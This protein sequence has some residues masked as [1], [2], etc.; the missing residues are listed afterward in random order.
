M[1][2][3]SLGYHNLEHL[4]QQG[5]ITI[6]PQFQLDTISLLAGKYGPF[7]P[8]HETEIPIWFALILYRAKVCKLKIPA[9]LAQEK[10]QEILRYEKENSSYYPLP[11]YA[12][13]TAKILAN[14]CSELLEG[15]SCDIIGKLIGEIMLFRCSKILKDLDVL[16]GTGITTP[17]IKI[18]N[19]TCKEVDKFHPIMLQI[20]NDGADLQNIHD[21]HSEDDTTL[22]DKPSRTESFGDSSL[23]TDLTDVHHSYELQEEE[24]STLVTGND[25]TST[26]NYK[27]RR[28]L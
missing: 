14:E 11:A 23:N 8:L 17:G 4:A 10:L 21:T 22:T 5:S 18:S 16:R 19:L 6:I 13:E 9:W 15:S 24:Q 2:S 1:N 28:A 25:F 7:R 20:L 27:K 12:P 3:R 26:S